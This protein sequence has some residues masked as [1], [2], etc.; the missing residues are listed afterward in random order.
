MKLTACS[1]PKKATRANEPLL[2]L[3]SGERVQ[4]YYVDDQRFECVS[5]SFMRDRWFRL[6]E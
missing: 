4:G 2:V 3:N 1:K 5:K 6:D